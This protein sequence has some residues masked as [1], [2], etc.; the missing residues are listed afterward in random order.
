MPTAVAAVDRKGYDL[1]LADIRLEDG[2]GF[3]VLAHCRVTRPDMAGHYDHRLRYRGD[4][5]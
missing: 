4:G 1:V 2:D 3:D 5:G